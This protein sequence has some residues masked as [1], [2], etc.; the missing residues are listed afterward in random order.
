MI[1]GLFPNR[2][3][4]NKQRRLKRAQASTVNTTVTISQNTGATYTGFTGVVLREANP[5][6]NFYPGGFGG[7]AGLSAGNNGA[8][9][10]SHSV[11]NI[12]GLSNLSNVTI[13]SSIIRFNLNQVSS[14]SGYVIALRKMLV[15]SN[16]SQATWNQSLTGTNWGAAGALLDNT[17]RSPTVL[18]TFSVVDSQLGIVEFKSQLL[19]QAIQNIV[20][21]NTNDRIRHKLHELIKKLMEFVSTKKT[22]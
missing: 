22:L 2:A 4:Y 5:T 16:V 21:G 9:D 19:T 15:A 17:D 12:S 6:N 3:P 20:D 14:A 11:L 1:K 7:T 10:R 18:S 8:G 13:L